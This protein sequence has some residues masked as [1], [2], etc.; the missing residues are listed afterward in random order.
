MTV[1]PFVAPPSPLASTSLPVAAALLAAAAAAT[2]LAALRRCDTPWRCW[3]GLLLCQ[4]ENLCEA[5]VSKSDRLLCMHLY[6]LQSG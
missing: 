3:I 4:L 2:C 5:Q 1:P 6:L